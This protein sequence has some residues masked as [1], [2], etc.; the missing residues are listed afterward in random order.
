M[1]SLAP[2]ILHLLSQGYV[3]SITKLGL[4]HLGMLEFMIA[5]KVSWL[6]C[7]FISKLNKRS[8]MFFLLNFNVKVCVFG[9]LAYVLSLLRLV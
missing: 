4:R 1:D 9:R 6:D 7:T 8:R 5:E 3:H 2:D